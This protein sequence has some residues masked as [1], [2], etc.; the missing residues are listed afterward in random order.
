MSELAAKRAIQNFISQSEFEILNGI[1]QFDVQ[2]RFIHNS[3]TPLTPPTGY[4]FLVVFSTNKGKRTLFDP[5]ND[6]AIRTKYYRINM[7]LVDYLY[8]VT[9]EGQLY[10]AMTDDFTIVTDRILDL[11][12]PE[13]EGVYFFD[14]NLRFRVVEG[15]EVACDT[16]PLFWE[17]AETYHASLVADITFEIEIC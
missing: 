3:R 7:M 11:L 14:D 4:F 13:D 5:V 16:T 15:S 2:R 17:E 10:E 1:V 12:D 9:G 8:A 6:L